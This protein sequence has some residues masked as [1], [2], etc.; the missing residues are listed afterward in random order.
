MIKK[1]RRTYFEIWG[2]EEAQNAILKGL[3]LG[4]GVLFIIQSV[5]LVVIS[6]RKPIFIAL[7]NEETKIFQVTPPSKELLTQEL[8]RTV[9]AYVETH[10]NWDSSTVEQAHEKAATYVSE[11]FV[12]AFVSANA[13]QVKI[14]KDK[15]LKEVVYVSDPI[16][17]DLSIL[18]AHVKLDRILIIDALRAT[19]AWN[20]DVTFE[21]GP[22]TDKNPEGIY[23]TGEK[24]LNP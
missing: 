16:Q 15:K 13:E 9:K 17:V 21:Y 1:I 2:D 14:A 11:K 12:K 20:L 8:K 4:L 19:T 5:A 23:V 3:L 22:R 24:Q 7:G 6:L 10:Y 18:T